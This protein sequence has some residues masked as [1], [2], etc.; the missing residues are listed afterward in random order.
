MKLSVLAFSMLSFLF[1]ICC[2]KWYFKTKWL[3]FVF[4]FKQTNKQLLQKLRKEL[5]WTYG[6]L[7][8]KTDIESMKDRVYGT[9]SSEANNRGNNKDGNNSNNNN[10]N[11]NN[12]D[13]NSENANGQRTHH[14]KN[15]SALDS[16]DLDF[17][18]FANDFDAEHFGQ[19]MQD[20]RTKFESKAKNNNKNSKNRENDNSRIEEDDVI[21]D[22]KATLKQIR[23][24]NESIRALLT[25]SGLVGSQSTQSTLMYNDA[26]ELA[27]ALDRQVRLSS[28][29]L[30]NLTA[31]FE[32][33]LAGNIGNYSGNGNLTG[34]SAEDSKFVS[35]L[36][37]RYQQMYGLFYM[38]SSEVENLNDALFQAQQQSEEAQEYIGELETRVRNLMS[39]ATQN[40]RFRM[41]CIQDGELTQTFEEMM[42]QLRHKAENCSA[43]ASDLYN[44]VEQDLVHLL[45]EQMSHEA[46]N[47]LDQYVRN[48]KHPC[49]F[50]QDQFNTILEEFVGVREFVH[51]DREMVEALQNQVRDLRE[52]LVNNFIFCFFFFI[53]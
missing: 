25:E 15:T 23:A 1:F 42:R 48:I 40:V 3:I 2:S 18:Q 46:S 43:A 35:K 26:K 37:K 24:E 28:K 21:R 14:K 9:N 47:L 41:E 50:I 39:S 53:F 16:I 31:Q 22:F 38:K 19:E 27:E 6:Q 8:A 10:G 29:K 44:C 20:A 13:G 45:P 49:K 32:T 30:I 12:K 5:Y 17:Y 33:I 11:G 36:E 4:T 51:P 34:K 52:R 7:Q